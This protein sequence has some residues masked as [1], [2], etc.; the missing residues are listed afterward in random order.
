VLLYVLIEAVHEVEGEVDGHAEHAGDE[1]LKKG[2][3]GDEIKGNETANLR[4]TGENSFAFITKCIPS[5][6]VH[7]ARA[8][9]CHRKRRL[10]P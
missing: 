9:P 5:K 3:G 2:K 7:L 1:G 4:S 6:N 10:A 8:E